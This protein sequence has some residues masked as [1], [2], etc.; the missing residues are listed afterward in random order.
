M[1][2]DDAVRE[3]ARNLQQAIA[4]AQ[5]EGYLV[6]WPSR[7]ADLGAIAVSETGRVG[8]AAPPALGAEYEVMTKA[9]LY[10]LATARGLDPKSDW[11][12]ADLIAALKG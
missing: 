4:V 10:E 6:A 7:P 3:A 12:K 1:T 9:G 2:P 8:A 11:T 5:A